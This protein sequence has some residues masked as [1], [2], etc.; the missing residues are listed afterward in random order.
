M[1]PR[2]PQRTSIIPQAFAISP[3]TFREVDD[4]LSALKMGT[5]QWF[6][7]DDVAVQLLAKTVQGFAQKYY[8]GPTGGAGRPWTIP[9]RRLTGRT[10]R[11]W[12]VRKVT[13]GAWEVFNEERGAYM[14]EYGIARYG[15][16]V[17]R[18]ILKMS[19]IATIRFVQ[20]TK[21]GERMMA[22]TWGN[23]RNNK[24]QFQSFAASMR[25]S[26]LLGVVGPTGRLPG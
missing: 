1:P 11:G 15:G 8:R 17:R 7:V 4:L 20:R 25:G 14:V 19:S 9:V 22:G 3:S 5:R 24:G 16:G 2:W 10:Y 12:Q 18:P 13:M 23:L 6:Q 26:S 21:F